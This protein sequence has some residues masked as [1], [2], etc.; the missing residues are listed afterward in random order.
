MQN[1]RAFLDNLKKE[2]EL[3]QSKIKDT[4]KYNAKAKRKKIIYKSCIYI[5]K[6][7]PY[8][9]A[10]TILINLNYFR[11]NSPFRIDEI[12]DYASIEEIH[13]SN[14]GTELKESYDLDYDNK[15]FEYCTGWYVNEHDLYEKVTT[16]Y[17][18]NEL[19]DLDVNTVLQMTPEEIGQLFT[20]INIKRIQ[21]SN[22]NDIE[23]EEQAAIRISTNSTTESFILRKETFWENV[24]IF[25]LY[26]LG[27][28]GLGIFFSL[29]ESK[30][31]K[32]KAKK[33]FEDKI[34]RYQIIDSS[35]ITKLK[36]IFEIK[37]DNYRLL[38][39]EE[40]VSQ[41]LERGLR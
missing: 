36:E 7:L 32:D 18:Y 8:I 2:L 15:I 13:N 3:L 39:S 38:T 26:L 41:I 33:Y 20:P 16:Y 31:L 19:R 5:D 25:L 17:Q 10:G 30:V 21:K 9:I 1:K 40:E 35:E 37:L 34:K 6:I 11:K 24:L 28:A 4:K 29:I 27:Q 22:L 23:K 14:G 12:E